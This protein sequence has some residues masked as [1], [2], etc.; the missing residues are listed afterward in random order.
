MG[1]GA[2]LSPPVRAN[3]ERDQ[4]TLWGAATEMGTSSLHLTME[5][6]D[7]PGSLFA[8]R[9]WPAM[10]GTTSTVFSRSADGCGASPPPT[11]SK[12]TTSA[13]REP[14]PDRLLP[15]QPLRPRQIYI[16]GPG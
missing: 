4:K 8:A 11:T 16:A 3:P 1:L 5:C 10:A 6:L 7:L 12:A 2:A 9:I 14:G 15:V 13:Y